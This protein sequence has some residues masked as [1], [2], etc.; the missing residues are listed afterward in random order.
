[1]TTVWSI[2][3]CVCMCVKGGHG[4]RDREAERK[5][6]KYLSAFCGGADDPPPP[7]RLLVW[8]PPVLNHHGSL[9]GSRSGNLQGGNK[10]S[11]RSLIMKLKAEQ[12]HPEDDSGEK[13]IE[14]FL[15]TALR[16]RRRRVACDSLIRLTFD[17]AVLL[18]TE[19]GA[20]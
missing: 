18:V 1:M 13:N 9:S 20:D 3:L 7:A 4:G 19:G 12:K 10:A 15:T 8:D 14:L 11:I 6:E 16:R 5:F 17:L 2:C